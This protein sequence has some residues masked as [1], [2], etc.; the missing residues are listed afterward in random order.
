MLLTP[1]VTLKPSTL[2]E[3]S[4]AFNLRKRVS[5]DKLI[6]EYVSNI[7]EAQ[8]KYIADIKRCNE[9]MLYN[10][11]ECLL[12]DKTLGTSPQEEDSNT[13]DEEPVKKMKDGTLHLRCPMLG[14]KIST[15]KLR[16]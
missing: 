8:K 15:Y 12:A 16:S 2:F 11:E 5:K 7:V 1:L 13:E 9:R 4:H 6:S 3:N 10:I 14:C